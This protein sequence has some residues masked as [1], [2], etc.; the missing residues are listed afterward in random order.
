MIFWLTISILIL[1]LLWI[2]C[3]IWNH[4]VNVSICKSNAKLVGKTAIVTGANSGIGLEITR[5]LYRRGARV[6]MACRDKR[7]AEKAVNHIST[8]VSKTNDCQ[9][10]E[11]I[12][13]PLDLASLNSVWQF[14]NQIKENEPRINLLVNN[15]GIYNHRPQCTD[16]DDLEIHMA[17]NHFGHFLLTNLLM[18]TLKSSAPSRVVAVGSF[19][20]SNGHIDFDTLRKGWVD[21]D[22]HRAYVNSKL[23]NA[24]FVRHFNLKYGPESGVSIYYADPG[25]VLTNIDR[26]TVPG[27]IQGFVHAALLAFFKFPSEACQTIVHCLLS[28]HVESGF[29]YC[30]C[31]KQDWKSNVLDDGIAKKFWEKCEDLTDIHPN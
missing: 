26:H 8:T 18:D 9:L 31:R 15:A 19:L 5:E 3:Y 17:S 20:Y 30:E 13:Y 28:E 6:I 1:F 25:I 2:A 4:Y 14:C 11:L 7:R 23:A 12:V 16:E 22:S 29:S 10:G 21:P 24:L 27:F